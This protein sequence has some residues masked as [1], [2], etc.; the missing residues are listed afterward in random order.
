MNNE[1]EM[2]FPTQ[3]RIST[4]VSSFY[5]IDININRELKKIYT[6][7]IYSPCCKKGEEI[8]TIYDNANSTYKISKV[9]KHNE[10]SKYVE[11]D[12]SQSREVIVINI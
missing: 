8:S 5:I 12:Y 3:A 11:M 2:K 9:H 6:P 1:I 10:N 4:N 7:I